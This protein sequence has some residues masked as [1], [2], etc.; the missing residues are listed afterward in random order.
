[1]CFSFAWRIHFVFLAFV[2][3]ECSRLG[4]KCFDRKFSLYLTIFSDFK[5]F[6]NMGSCV[7]ATVVS[8]SLV[9]ENPFI[10]YDIIDKQQKFCGL[11]F[12]P[13]LLKS[14]MLLCV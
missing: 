2:K 10:L 13:L 6:E 14:A 3:I 1:M 11:V 5:A 4:V 8:M 7:V 9:H 12:R